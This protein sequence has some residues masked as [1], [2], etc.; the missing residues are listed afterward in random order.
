MKFYFVNNP[1]RH[2]SVII[3]QIIDTI[4]YA[5]NDVSFGANP[6]A[7]TIF[8]TTGCTDRIQ[9]LVERLSM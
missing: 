6:Q 3:R 8:A 1:K 7:S 9:T 2:S 5:T 4:I